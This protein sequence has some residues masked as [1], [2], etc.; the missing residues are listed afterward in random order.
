MQI[1]TIQN[2]FLSV[3]VKHLGAELCSLKKGETEYM[4]QADATHW[5]RHAPVLFP[6]I[7]ELKNGEFHFEGKTYAMKRHG[8]ARNLPFELVKQTKDTLIFS[9]KSSENTLKN[10]PF[11][12]ELQISYTLVENQ[13]TVGYKV[14]NTQK[15]TIYFSI[16]GHPAFNV[17][18]HEN[19]KR[20]DY[21]LVFNKNEYVATQRLTNGLRNGVTEN[22]LNNQNTIA[23]TDELFEKDALVFHNLNSNQVSIQKGNT[24][25]LTFDFTGFPYLGIWSSSSIAPFV[26]IE[27]WCGVADSITHNQRIVEKEGI[28]KLSDE[29]VFERSYFIKIGE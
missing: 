5:N 1:S 13:L 15:E 3:S 19:E 11:Q 25:I 18:L 27:P 10:Y 7:G 14:I 8:L 17:P 2:Q 29:E 4:W 16:G 21:Q 24:K 9:L 12:F 22:V 23:I 6:V 28:V 26:C 20:S